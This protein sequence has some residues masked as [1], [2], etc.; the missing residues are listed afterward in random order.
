MREGKRLPSGRDVVDQ[1]ICGC[2]D[3]NE[4]GTVVGL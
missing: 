2:F 4:Y 1:N 3:G